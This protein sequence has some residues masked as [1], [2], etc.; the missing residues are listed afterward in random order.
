M[1]EYSDPKPIV[2]IVRESN[3]VPAKTA[4][5]GV[6]EGAGIRG[7]ERDARKVRCVA[8]VL[9]WPGDEIV[10]AKGSIGAKENEVVGTWEPWAPVGVWRRNEDGVVHAVPV[11]GT[12]VGCVVSKT[13]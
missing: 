7:R 4:S 10:P 5:E 2:A 3:L 6:N 11:A 8:V 13:V 9:L 12:M 1:R